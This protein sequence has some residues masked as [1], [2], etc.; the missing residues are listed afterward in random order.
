LLLLIGLTGVPAL[1][2]G[3]EDSSIKNQQSSAT[4]MDYD[5]YYDVNVFVFGRCDLYIP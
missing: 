1:S 4:G 5:E 3:L 2:T